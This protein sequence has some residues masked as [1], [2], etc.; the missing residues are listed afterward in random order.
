MLNTYIYKTFIN[1][2]PN[3]YQAVSDDQF[4]L[5]FPKEMEVLRYLISKGY[6]YC[7][8][9]SALYLFSDHTERTIVLYLNNIQRITKHC[10]ISIK[11][12]IPT[13]VLQNQNL[14]LANTKTLVIHNRQYTQL[15]L[16]YLPLM[17]SMK[18]CPYPFLIPM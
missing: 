1:T 12:R 16:F 6:F 11:K 10:K 5:T 14:C 9:P 17:D 7:Y 4:C 13:T 18:A 8:L 3:S 15:I 2:I